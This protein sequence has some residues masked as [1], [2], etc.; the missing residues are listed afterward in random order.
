RT[1]SS[2]TEAEIDQRFQ[3]RDSY[4]GA[5][6][7]PLLLAPHDPYRPLFQETFPHL[8]LAQTIWEVD[9]DYDKP[10]EKWAS[11]FQIAAGVLAFLGFSST[12]ALCLFHAMPTEKINQ[13]VGA[14][15][16]SSLRE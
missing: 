5:V 10:S 16:Q 14:E 1:S 11:G 4:R 13:P 15:L 6:I 7:N 3:L 8:K 12:A 2:K 9:V